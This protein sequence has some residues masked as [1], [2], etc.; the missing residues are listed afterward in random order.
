VDAAE[1]KQMA[2][3]EWEAW[4]RH[5]HSGADERIAPEFH[6]HNAAPGTPPGPEGFRQVA[7]RLWTAFP[8]MSFE[9]EEVFTAENRVAVLGWM[10]GTQE[11]QFGPFPA[12][13]K[14]F[15]VRQIH[16][17]RVNDEGL[18]IEHLAVRDDVAMLQELGHLPAGE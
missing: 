16:T 2:E 3:K 9:I 10:S 18:L 8:D 4:N 11:G 14:S 5:D 13:G 17:F 15:R 1:L 6:N 12:K 7:T